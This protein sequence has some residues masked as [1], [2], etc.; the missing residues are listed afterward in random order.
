MRLLPLFGPG[1]RGIFMLA[2]AAIFAQ[3]AVAQGGSV[4][5][6]ALIDQ[7]CTSCHNS[8]DYAAGLDLQGADATSV[9]DSP[10]MGEKLIKRLRA[11][12]MPP[13]GE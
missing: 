5:T 7:Y 10:Q 6:G 13:V 4:D 8:V 12:M 3:G 1:T 11:G 9:A 2:G